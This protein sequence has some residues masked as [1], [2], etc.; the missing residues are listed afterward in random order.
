MKKILFLTLWVFFIVPTFALTTSTTTRTP[1]T[2]Y[3][4]SADFLRDYGKR[5]QVASDGCNTIQIVNGKLGA[6]TQKYCAEIYGTSGVQNWSCQKE[7]GK[8]SISELNQLHAFERK[9][10]KSTIKSVKNVETKFEKLAKNKSSTQVKNAKQ[11]LVK[12]LEKAINNL[13]KKYPSGKFPSKENEIF[14][15]LTVLKLKFSQ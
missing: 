10:S 8:L 2:G 13:Y 11:K 14:M 9:I 7:I 15:A 3:T 12:K 4:N 1:T 5:C 6:S